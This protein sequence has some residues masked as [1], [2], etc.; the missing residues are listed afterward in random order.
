MVRTK[1]CK[2]QSDAG[3]VRNEPGIYLI[4]S[5]ATKKTY[6]GSSYDIKTRLY[7][8]HLRKLKKKR[9]YNSRMQ[10]HVNEYGIDDL[11]VHA[12]EYCSI[13]KLITREQYYINKIRPEFNIRRIA[14]SYL[15]H[16]S[17]DWEVLNIP[18]QKLKADRLEKYRY[19]LLELNKCLMEDFDTDILHSVIF[20]SDFAKYE[21]VKPL[22]DVYKKQ[23]KEN[24]KIAIMNRGK[25]LKDKIT[26]EKVHT[27]EKLS[28]KSGLC[29]TTLRK[30]IYI[31]KYI[32]KS[33]RD[34][35]YLGETTI[36]RVFEEI[37]GVKLNKK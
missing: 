31:D 12:L 1:Y 22:V 27:H 18:V 24:K 32:D 15:D 37:K 4:R 11:S 36:G 7:A 25:S 5:K 3:D 35:L 34:S 8:G 2:K 9:H 21:L 28:K 10:N 6:V 17:W 23:A 26:I 20:L 16:E 14:T 33:T 30:A 29:T 13:D 19:H